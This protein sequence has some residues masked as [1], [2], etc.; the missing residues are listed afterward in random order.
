MALIKCPECGKEISDKA[1]VCINCGFPLNN[2]T[3]KTTANSL[4]NVHIHHTKPFSIFSQSNNGVS[5]ECGNCEKVYIF[6]RIYFSDISDSHCIPN[7]QITCPNCGN[8]SDEGVR[9]ESK[10]FSPDFK[11]SKKFNISDKLNSKVKCPICGSDS[12]ATVNRGFSIWTGF[13]GSGSPRNVCQKCGH[14]W[15]P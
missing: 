12:I 5:L 1:T 10:V 2:I 6:K 8:S 14:K 4:P 7:T 11:A 13:L 15:K 3:E 9:I